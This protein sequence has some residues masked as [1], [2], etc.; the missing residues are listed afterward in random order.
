[1]W[2]KEEGFSLFRGGE[3]TVQMLR[4]GERHD[5]RTKEFCIVGGKCCKYRR[6]KSGHTTL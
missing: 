6:V 5:V 1:M 4:V 2:I 3:L